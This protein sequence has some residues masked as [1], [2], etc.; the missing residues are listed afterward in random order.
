MLTASLMALRAT[1]LYMAPL[2][3]YVNPSLS[4]TSLAVVLLPEAAGPSTA[5]IR[6]ATLVRDERMG[7]EVCPVGILEPSHFD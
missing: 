7:L 5:M 4:A 1:V 6:F 2:S 3:M